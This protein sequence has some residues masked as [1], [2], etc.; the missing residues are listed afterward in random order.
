MDEPTA[1]A[2][3]DQLIA[4]G[5]VADKD[6]DI[7]PTKRWNA[8]LQSA[9]EKLNQLAAQMGQNPEGNPLVLAVTQALAQMNLTQDPALFRVACEMLLTLELSRMTPAKRA[10]MGFPERLT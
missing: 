1:E 4:W 5:L 2:A 10:Q 7:T 6:G 3:L 9:A 8:Q